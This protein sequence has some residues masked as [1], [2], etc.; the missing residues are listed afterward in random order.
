MA[1]LFFIMQSTL[2]GQNAAEFSQFAFD[3]HGVAVV[4]RGAAVDVSQ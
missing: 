1:A 2:V 3:T 4:L